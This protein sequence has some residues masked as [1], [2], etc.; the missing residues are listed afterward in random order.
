MNVR[1]GEA[2]KTVATA[3]HDK[4]KIVSSLIETYMSIMGEMKSSQRR[5]TGGVAPQISRIDTDIIPLD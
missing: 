3:R 5:T 2:A 4:Q 1:M